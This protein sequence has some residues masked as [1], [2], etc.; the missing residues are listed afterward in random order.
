MRIAPIRR[1]LVERY[2]AVALCLFGPASVLGAQSAGSCPTTMLSVYWDPGLHMWF[3]GTSSI[4]Q[5]RP[6]GVLYEF[7]GRNMPNELRVIGRHVVGFAQCDAAA[8][9]SMMRIPAEI[10]KFDTASFIPQFQSVPPATACG[11]TSGPGGPGVPTVRGGSLKSDCALTGAGSAPSSGGGGGTV[12]TI[13]TC[14]YT[15]YFTSSG[16]YLY[17]ELEYCTTE[18]IY[19]T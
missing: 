7:R 13:S 5:V 6:D 11:T 9:Q 12:V 14:H 15:A 3:G 19:T 1:C 4:V 8:F 10:L 2:L 16:V 17:T 18:W